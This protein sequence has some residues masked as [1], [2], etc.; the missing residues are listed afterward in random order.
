LEN[1]FSIWALQGLPTLLNMEYFDLA[2]QLKRDVYFPAS[3]NAAEHLSKHVCTGGKDVS[4]VLIGKKNLHL[5]LW[6]FMWECK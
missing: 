2:H 5:Q 6:L 3:E 4:S 1:H